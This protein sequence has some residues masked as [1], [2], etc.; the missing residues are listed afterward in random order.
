MVPLTVPP[1]EERPR[2]N[3]GKHQKPKPLCNELPE[4]PAERKRVL[5][6]LAQR[7]YSIKHLRLLLHI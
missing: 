6:V 1:R 5:N 4:D 3:V 2:A 7:R